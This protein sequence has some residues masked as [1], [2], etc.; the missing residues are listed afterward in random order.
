MGRLLLVVEDAFV[1]ATSLVV[2]PEPELEATFTARTLT[3]E[4]RR[5]DGSSSVAE[6]KVKLPH[7]APADR[8][9]PQRRLLAFDGLTKEDVPAGTEIWQKRAMMETP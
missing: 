9:K 2:M 3:V 5:P 6:A 7:L 8:S 1:V 4:L